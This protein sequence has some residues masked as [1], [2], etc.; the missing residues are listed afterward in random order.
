MILKNAH[1][2][3]M[4]KLILVM[5]NLKEFLNYQI[6]KLLNL[7]KKTNKIKKI[8]MPMFLILVFIKKSFFL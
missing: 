1:Y 8:E 5:I 4:I 6:L 3:H 2:I 7:I